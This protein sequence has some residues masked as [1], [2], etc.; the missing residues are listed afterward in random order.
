MERVRSVNRILLI[1]RVVSHYNVP[2]YEKIAQTYDFKVAFS[3]NNEDLYHRIET[4]KIFFPTGGEFQRMNDEEF[5]K[6][7]E[8][9]TKICREFDA[10]ILPMEP[11]KKILFVI[12]RL[13]K[14]VKV[15]LWGIGVAASYDTRYD[16][17]DYRNPS[18]ESMVAMA[19]AA[20]FY[21]DYP[22]NKYLGRGIPKEKMF[23]ALNTVNVIKTEIQPF[24]KESI[25]F[26]GTL[27]KQKRLDILLECYKESYD[28][29]NSIP[30]LKIIGEGS[31]F[32]NLSGWIKEAGLE[33]QV[34]LKGPIYNEEE[35]KEEFL[36]S[37]ATISAD[38]AGLS[39][40]KSMGY[41]V[42]FITNRNAITGGEIF[43]IEHD[44]N[45]MLF[46]ENEELVNI[47]LDIS[48]NRDKYI[49]MGRKAQEYYYTN[50]TVS[51]C[52]Q[53]FCSAIN[54]AIS[55]GESYD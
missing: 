13:R 53:G 30:T 2:I 24:K 22:R 44:I 33:H 45:G 12:E 40:L 21:T 46:D 25:L 5:D 34:F 23:V 16:S 6:Y 9:L 11:F 29:D 48:K 7:M 55:G 35:L 36:S 42:P 49:D 39:V 54:Y 38:Q 32:E 27:I 4:M 3:E 26:V 8:Y 51:N 15:L 14:K 47:I 19:D 37:F 18:F 43:N 10:V 50:A 1:Q 20:I 52:A 17:V 41:G 28:I 31:E